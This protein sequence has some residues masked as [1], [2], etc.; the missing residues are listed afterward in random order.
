MITQQD[1]LKIL[2]L[3]FGTTSVFDFGRCPHPNSPHRPHDT[4]RSPLEPPLPIPG[5]RHG[6]GIRLAASSV[7]HAVRKRGHPLGHKTPLH[8]PQW[9]L[10]AFLVEVEAD[11]PKVLV[12][13]PEA[14]RALVNIV[15]NIF[16]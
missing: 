7:M 2:L 5:S 11:L 16:P 3:K 14:A 1:D 4:H 12:G 15:T 8:C 9:K 13:Q 10:I 6:S